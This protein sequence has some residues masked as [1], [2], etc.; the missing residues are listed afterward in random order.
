MSK[1]LGPRGKGKQSLC[2]HCW[3]AW[4][5]PFL[6]I[7]L[8]RR[9]RKSLRVILHTST[10]KRYPWVHGQCLMGKGM[11]SVGGRRKQKTCYC[12]KHLCEKAFAY[13]GLHTEIPR[14]EWQSSCWYKRAK[15]CKFRKRFWTIHSIKMEVEALSADEVGATS[16]AEVICCG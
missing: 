3:D 6:A 2:W 8:L 1:D 10:C 14:N 4:E 11:L 13:K 12:G 16:L 9:N 5:R 7:L 15:L